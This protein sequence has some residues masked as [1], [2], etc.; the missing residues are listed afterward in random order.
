MVNALAAGEVLA[1][2]RGHSPADRDRLVKALGDKAAVQET[3][4]VC[5][6]VVTFNTKKKPFD[7][8]RVRQALSLAIDRWGGA[9]ALSKVALVRHVGGH[10]AAR[11]RSRGQ[12]EGTARLSRLLQGH[13]RFARAGAQA[14]AGSGRAEPHVHAHQ[15]QRRDAVH[16]GRRVPD[17]PVA[18]DRGDRQARAARDPALPRRAAARQPDLRRGA[19]LQLRLHGRAQPAAAEIPVARPL[20][21]STTRSRPTACST[22]S[23]TSSR[24]SSTRRS[25]MPS[26]ASSRSARSSRRTPSRPSGGTASSCTH[27]QLKGWHITPSH[28]VG[29]DLADV[30]LDQ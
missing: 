4:W 22:I 25:A 15:P 14:A 1:E 26:C 20:A 16:A 18:A 24:A 27:K 29:Q 30:W 6:L 19:R 9:Q 5:S 10:P 28:Y 3:P 21:R 13:Q 23:S 2:F 11:L 8:V 12:R 17:R 7:D